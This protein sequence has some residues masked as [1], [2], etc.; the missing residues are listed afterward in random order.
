MGYFG[1]GCRNRQRWCFVAYK[2]APVTDGP[3]AHPSL[4]IPA[5]QLA[6]DTLADHLATSGKPRRS[7]FTTTAGTPLGHADAS[8]VL[9]TYGI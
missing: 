7:R 3:S 8:L 6:F 4:R 5:P 9:S 2:G 1:D